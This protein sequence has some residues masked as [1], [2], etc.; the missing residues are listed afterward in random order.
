M[1][2]SGD[3]SLNL[4]I[5]F[6]NIKIA[7]FSSLPVMFFRLSEPER[8]LSPAALVLVQQDPILRRSSFVLGGASLGAG[9]AAESPE[10]IKGLLLGL[11]E[12][13]ISYFLYQPAAFKTSSGQ[14]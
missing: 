2:K 3:E 13:D 1:V 4:G 9:D 12:S 8:N 7:T 6:L 10:L 5:L 14:R 11:G